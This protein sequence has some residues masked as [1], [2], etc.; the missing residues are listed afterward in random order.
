MPHAKRIVVAGIPLHITQRG[1][2]RSNVFR[3]NEDRCVYLRLFVQALAYLSSSAF[4]L[5]AR[6]SMR[7]TDY[8][9]DCGKKDLARRQW[10]K[11]TF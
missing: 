3:D 11:P 1:V 4:D 8:T 6:S 7:N 2:R 5:R 9:A 10:I